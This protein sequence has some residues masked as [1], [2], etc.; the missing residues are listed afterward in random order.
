[1]TW[2]FLYCSTEAQ[3]HSSIPAENCWRSLSSVRANAVIFWP[4]S[5]GITQEG[6]QIDRSRT[7]HIW[8]TGSFNAD[9]LCCTSGKLFSAHLAFSGLQGG[10]RSCCASLALPFAAKGKVAHRSLSIPLF[11]YLT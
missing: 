5:E 1:M 6:F 11:S 10:R 3:A 7:S 4:F 9:S 8:H 2:A